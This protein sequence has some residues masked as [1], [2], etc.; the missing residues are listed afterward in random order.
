MN[1]PTMKREVAISVTEH[2]GRTVFLYA[3]PDAAEV[4]SGL[5]HIWELSSPNY[6]HLTV[7]ARYDFD[8]VV[9]FIE[10]YGEEKGR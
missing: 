7:D 4:F 10:G 3:T 9:R 1:K 2:T 5:G 8:E 6:Y